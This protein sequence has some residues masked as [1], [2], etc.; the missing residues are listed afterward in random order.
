MLAEFTTYYHARACYTE[1]KMHSLY[2]ISRL[3]CCIRNA[4]LEICG[5]CTPIVKICGGM[6]V[7]G[8]KFSQERDYGSGGEMKFSVSVLL[9][10][11]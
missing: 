7:F 10:R 2:L 9:Y 3:K 8:Q 1:N 6:C 5:A 4:I 11:E